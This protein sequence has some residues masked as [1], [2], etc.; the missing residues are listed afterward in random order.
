MAQ[1][2]LNFTPKGHAWIAVTNTTPVVAEVRFTLYKSDGSIVG[3]RTS[4]IIAPNGQLAMSSTDIFRGNGGIPDGS[5]IQA[6]STVTGLQGFYFS[7][8]KENSFDGAEA[9]NPLPS[10]TIPLNLSGPGRRTSLLVTNPGAQPVEVTVS[11]LSGDG[12]PADVQVK[13]P[14]APHEQV[15]IAAGGGMAI[16]EADSSAGVLATA[17]NEFDNGLSLVPGQAID[18]RNPRRWVIPYFRNQ[19]GVSSKLVLANPSSVYTDV[20][21]AFYDNNGQVRHQQPFTVLANG[22]LVLDWTNITGLPIPPQGEGWLLIDAV[23]PLVGAAF[24]ESGESKTAIPMQV[25]G[26]TRILF[27]R[28]VSQGLPT[29]LALVGDADRDATVT[30]TLTRPDGSTAAQSSAF[31]LKRLSR[32]EALISE[33]VATDNFEAGFLTIQS[34]V[35][36]FSAELM[37]LG[38]GNSQS[39][40]TPQRPAATFSPGPATGLPRI[41][42]AVD[43]TLAPGAKLKIT[44]ENV[45]AD[46]TLFVEGV[47]VPMIAEPTPFGLDF[48]ATLPGTL[49][50]GRIRV[51][52]R[53]A[54]VESN[55]VD[56]GVYSDDVAFSRA[57]LTISGYAYFQKID[58]TDTG[59]DL[60]QLTNVPVRHALVEV[61]DNLGSVISVSKTDEFG[62][63][64]VAVP[65]RTGLTIRIASRLRSQ[66]LKVLNNTANNT[67]L[68]YLFK[69][70]NSQDRNVELIESTRAAGA[71][72]ILDA[73][74]RGNTLIMNAAPGLV[75]PALTV[76]WSDKNDAAALGKLTN[77]LIRTTFFNPTT[78]SAYILGDRNTDS[79]EFDDSVILHEYGHLLAAKFSRDDSNGGIHLMGDSLDPRIAW[80]EGWANFFSSA[81][82]G[83]SVYRDS[84][85]QNN[86]LRFDL[87]ENVPVGDHAGYASEAS[88]GG[89]L[90]DLIDEN[91]DKDDVAQFPF[92]A[93]WA[94]FTDLSKERNVYLP[95]FL[96]RFLLRNVGV[97]DSLRTMVIARSIDFQP[98]VR[99]SVTNP[100]PRLIT[101]GQSQTGQVD[102]Y[103]TKRTNLN[104]SSHFFS[105]TTATGGQVFIRLFPDGLGP[106]NR[107]DANDLDLFLYD[108]TGRKIIAQSDSP[109]NGG[110]EIIPMTLS[111]GTYFIEVRSFY[112]RDET[113]STVF[114]S[115]GYRLEVQRPGL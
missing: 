13:R 103:T 28:A 30:V 93:I 64:D 95:L 111:P 2:V 70:L 49:D 114:N 1:S 12:T 34:S 89:L 71:F 24:I 110:G 94:A 50:P 4:R 51:Y 113:K 92:A 61:V 57:P 43:G 72:N 107:P 83:N 29:R 33:F 52:V 77:G 42:V 74:Q 7:G 6:T 47:P 79:D 17:V 14:L 3:N 91:A 46:A 90:W 63:F 8:D 65:D 36:L 9:S 58:V 73:L 99:P 68:Y 108:S 5:W 19:D 22:S 75:P 45:R 20:R 82:R 112:V 86:V 97:S 48:T 106:A 80:S 66:D 35:P 85:A 69:V 25:A 101:I 16:V 59:L 115:G 105:L 102:S 11:F 104:N 41:K 37:A 15:S 23:A 60:S 54:G 39:A 84:K 98:D 62:K 81:A 100:F 53:S 67:P 109:I 78:N 55:P 18:V 38:D 21:V 26:S 44:S 56:L 32:K 27:S 10:Q 96:E 76:Y 87:E 31:L 88:V 40:I